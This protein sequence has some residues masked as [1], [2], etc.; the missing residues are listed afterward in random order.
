M[1]TPIALFIFTSLFTA[2]NLGISDVMKF[3]EAAETN[4][5]TNDILNIRVSNETDVDIQEVKIQDLTFSNVEAQTT[6]P[7]Q[8]SSE[9][10]V[11]HLDQYLFSGYGF[12]GTPPI[13]TFEKEGT[14]TIVINEID[15]ENNTYTFLEIEE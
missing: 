15:L 13:P 8:G 9:T 12:C 5:Q 7:Y 3:V 11:Y 14:Y 2:C 6:T 10:T 1:R 4:E